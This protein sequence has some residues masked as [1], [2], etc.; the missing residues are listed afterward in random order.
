MYKSVGVLYI[1]A[2]ERDHGEQTSFIFSDL[3]CPPGGFRLSY[4]TLIL[5]SLFFEVCTHFF[6]ADPSIQNLHGYKQ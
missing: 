6:P 1:E 4:Q 5:S 3:S 2:G